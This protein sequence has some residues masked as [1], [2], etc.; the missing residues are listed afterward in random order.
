MHIRGECC[1]QM[2]ALSLFQAAQQQLEYLSLQQIHIAQL[3]GRLAAVLMLGEC[4]SLMAELSLFQEML[5]QLGYLT[6]LRMRTV[7]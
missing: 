2:A 1:F 6:H 7:Q 3:Q 5:Q 4:L